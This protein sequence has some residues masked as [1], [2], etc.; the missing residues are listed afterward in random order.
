MAVAGSH[1]QNEMFLNLIVLGGNTEEKLRAAKNAGFDAVEIWNEDVDSYFGGATAVRTLANNLEIVFT[2]CM[3]LRY[4]A[5]APKSLREE[6]R[7]AALAMLER[8]VALGTDAIQSP[9]TTLDDCDPSTVDSDLRWLCDEAS[10]YG[11][12]VCYEP[13]AW[14]VLDHTLP[15]AWERIQRIGAENLGIV[16]DMFHICSRG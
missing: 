1:L 14:S 9:A 3:V 12:R 11:I 10:R 8:A 13:M 16:V 15:A 5:G 6:K 2:D 7:S 4:F